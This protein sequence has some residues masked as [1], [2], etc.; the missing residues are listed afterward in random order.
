MVKL[1]LQEHIVAADGQHYVR[2]GKVALI[3][4]KPSADETTSPILQLFSRPPRNDGSLVARQ[5]QPALVF[6]IPSLSFINSENQL[7]YRKKPT[8]TG[9][10]S[11]RQPFSHFHL[12]LSLKAV[13]AWMTT[14]D[15]PPESAY[16]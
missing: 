2:Q 10:V 7:L 4:E 8:R 15:G 13:P 9:P 16:A 1:R 14:G 6:R 12:L 3:A 11:I 5:R